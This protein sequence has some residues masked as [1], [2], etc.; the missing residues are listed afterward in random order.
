MFCLYPRSHNQA[1]NP[2]VASHNSQSEIHFFPLVL[3]T[4]RYLTPLQI[5][6]LPRSTPYHPQCP[7]ALLAHVHLEVSLRPPVFPWAI[8]PV[9]R[10]ELKC[11]LSR[12]A[13]Q[14]TLSAAAP[15]S[16]SAL[17]TISTLGI[18]PITTVYLSSL[19]ICLFLTCVPP[20]RRSTP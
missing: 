2:S 20:A 11:H 3:V 19:L 17:C 1:S 13:P 8:L 5:S 4:S 7:H 6:H 18:V 10:T 14:T 15:P 9:I 16:S 12:E